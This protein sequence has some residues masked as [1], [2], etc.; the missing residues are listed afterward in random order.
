MPVGA[1]RF[2]TAKLLGKLLGSPA[3]VSTALLVIALNPGF[4]RSSSRAGPP[5]SGTLVCPLKGLTALQ[6]LDC[7]PTEAAS[8]K[9]L[10]SL[11]ELHIDGLP[12]R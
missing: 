5:A 1:P 7:R 11:A 2:E 3:V 6:W 10:K 4:E 9:A 12:P 8:V